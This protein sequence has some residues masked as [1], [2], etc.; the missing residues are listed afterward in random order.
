MPL[1]SMVI[2]SFNHR[3]YILACIESVILQDY[4]NIE[5]I[6]IDDG[7]TDD[8]VE[9]IRGE[10]TACKKRFARFEFRSRDNKGVAETINEAIEWS[11]GIYFAA[12]ASDDL[13][14]P[15]K[16][17]VLVRNID[18]EGLDVAGIFSGCELINQSG[19]V[20]GS[21]N[22][23]QKKM[24][25]EDIITCKYIIPASSQL[26][27]LEKVKEVGC[28]PPQL[29]I[30]DW[31][32]WLAL[33]DKGYKLKTI[34]NLLVQYRHHASNT[35]KNSLKMLESRKIILS[36]YEKHPLYLH[37]LAL[38]YISA[39]I[40]YSFTSKKKALVYLLKAARLNLKTILTQHFL[41]A[42]IMLFMPAFITKWLVS[43]RRL[44]AL[45]QRK[46]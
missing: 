39:A 26:L 29:C 35:S 10:I 41:T 7:S 46:R 4:R 34:S 19:A 6:I 44:I 28:Y 27:R 15:N 3:N 8:S 24:T 20:V 43:V 38:I 32:M 17:S 45:F 33:T 13:L 42:F 16:T 40:D 22:F 18:L 25:F 12:I 30:E 14:L 31:Y 21:R 23:T 37:A 5:L 2:P 1:V 11:K 36:S 9:K